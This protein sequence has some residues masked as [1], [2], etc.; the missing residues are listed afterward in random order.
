MFKRDGG[1]QREEDGIVR[2]RR[3]QTKKKKQGILSFPSKREKKQKKDIKKS[4]LSF[5][6]QPALKE[7]TIQM[8]QIKSFRFRPVSFRKFSS[9]KTLGPKEERD[10]AKPFAHKSAKRNLIR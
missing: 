5:F 1:I 9:T 2:N 7:K 8:N 3:P 4:Q 6:P 10:V